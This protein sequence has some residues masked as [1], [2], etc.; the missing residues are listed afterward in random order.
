MKVT[1]IWVNCNIKLH[2]SP[3][4]LTFHSIF[5]GFHSYL[6]PQS[7]NKFYSLLRVVHTMQKTP[8]YLRT[9]C[10]IISDFRR[11]VRRKNETRPTPPV[12]QNFIYTTYTP[13]FSSGIKSWYFSPFTLFFFWQVACFQ[14]NT[15]SLSVLAENRLSSCVSSVPLGLYS[16][17]SLIMWLYHF[18]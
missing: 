2:I 1:F 13:P 6:S 3:T 10:Q 4:F 11:Q 18:V 5:Y 7:L 14:N 15:S 9:F 8:T 12:F 16:F 17:H